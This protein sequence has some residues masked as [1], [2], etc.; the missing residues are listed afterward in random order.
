MSENRILIFLN[1]DETINVG[2]PIILND[3]FLSIRGRPLSGEVVLN[4]PD[5]APPMTVSISSITLPACEADAVV[6]FDASNA[7]GA[8]GREFEVTWNA[9]SCDNLDVNDVN[10]VLNPVHST[11]LAFNLTDVGFARKCIAVK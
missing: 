10:R 5:N 8:L 11:L 2:D 1:G 6:E 7:L 3:G 9:V 4:A